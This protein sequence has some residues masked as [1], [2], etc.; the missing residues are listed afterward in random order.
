MVQRDDLPDTPDWQMPRRCC[1]TW[2]TELSCEV[3]GNWTR[4]SENITLGSE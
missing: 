4:L 3:C 2:T 1:A